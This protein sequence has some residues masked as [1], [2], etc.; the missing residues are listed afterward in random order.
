MRLPA[1]DEPFIKTTDSVTTVSLT[2][3]P[4]HW[5]ELDLS[6]SPF[7]FKYIA[8]TAQYQYGDLPPVFTLVDH[9]VSVGLTLKAAQ[10]SKAAVGPGLK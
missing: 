4:R 7:A 10:S 3:K 1:F 9:K 2:T 5:V 6:Y 8:F